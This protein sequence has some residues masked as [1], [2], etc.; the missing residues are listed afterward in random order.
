MYRTVL[1]VA[2]CLLGIFVHPFDPGILDFIYRFI[3]F[4]IIVYLVYI[5]YK[6]SV[7]APEETIEP[8]REIP[9]KREQIFELSDDWHIKELIESD[10]RSEKFLKDQ[11]DIIA[12]L[13]FP[14]NGWIFFKDSEELIVLYQKGFSDHS[15]SDIQKR[16]PITGLLQILN[17]TEDMLIENNIN[18][19]ENLL[20]LYKDVEYSAASF[21][22]LPV[23]LKEKE[24]IFIVFDSHNAEHFNQD[25]IPLFKGLVENT[26]IWF[27]NR[28]KA[29]T[30]LNELKQQK[31][32][33]DFAKELN[34]T[35]VINIAIERFA[36]LISYEFEASRLTISLL[37]KGKNQGV[38]KKVIGQKD[39]FEE[40]TVFSLDEG[41]TGWIISKNKPYLIEDLEKGEY[42]I[43]RYSKDEKTNLGLRSFLGVPIAAND[44]VFGA[45]TIEHRQANKYLEN[46]KEKIKDI[47]DIFSTTFLRSSPSSTS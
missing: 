4:S 20:P 43:P 39:D 47:V 15:I 23:V 18:K 12:N 35:K 46:D 3:V 14:D 19:A 25:D 17:N 21:L 28:I 29:Y 31:L 27:I 33:T 13:V 37:K 41:L 1:I 32:L 38:I 42:F 7:E 26:A 10:E 2:L 8:I 16:Y 36:N 24:K 6:Q 44:Q 40:N 45:V 11:F 9:Q 5:F 22:G 34:S 30:L